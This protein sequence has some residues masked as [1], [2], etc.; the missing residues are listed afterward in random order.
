MKRRFLTPILLLCCLTI[1]PAQSNALNLMESFFLK[2]TV[3]ENGI[4][5]QWEYTSPGKYEY[6]KGEKVIKTKEAKDEL[7]KIVKEINLS[8]EA[9]IEKMVEILKQ[10]RFPEIEHLDIRW[11]TGDNKLYTWVWDHKNS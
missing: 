2:I 10:N 9:K 4:E 3:I 8:E 5:H 6:E 1:F 11:M 7:L